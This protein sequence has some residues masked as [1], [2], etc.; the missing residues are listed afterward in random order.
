MQ[1]AI[2][3]GEAMAVASGG[4]RLAATYFPPAPGALP[5]LGV[6]VIVLERQGLWGLNLAV[7]RALAA[8]GYP[9][10]AVDGRGDANG[11]REAARLADVRAAIAAL[12]QRTAAGRVLLFAPIE[13]AGAVARAAAAEGAAGV[14]LAG[15]RL[16]PAAGPADLDV[17]D[18]LAP[19][20]GPLLLLGTGDTEEHGPAVDALVA[21]AAHWRQA[22]ARCHLEMGIVDGPRMMLPQGGDH[23]ISPAN[24]VG[25]A[26]ELTL[27]WIERRYGPG[28]PR[29][30]QGPPPSDQP[31]P[32]PLD[33]SPAAAVPVLTTGSVLLPPDAGLF[34]DG[35]AWSLTLPDGRAFALTDAL[36]RLVAL[37]DGHRNVGQIAAALSAEIG[38]NLP[39]EQVGRLLRE[40]LA[41]LGVLEPDVRGHGGE[42]DSWMTDILIRCYEP[43]DRLRALLDNLT[44]VTRPP[45][46]LILVVGKRHAVLNQHVGLDRART[47]YAVFLDDDVILTEGWVERLRETM[48][49]T[50][51]GAVSARQLRMDGSPLSTAGACGER[52]VVEA[53]SGGACFM[54][55]NDLG[56]RFDETYVRSQWDDVDFMFQLYERGLR[57]YVDGRV[58]FYHHNDP[59]VWR[60]QNL[61]HFVE[62]WLGK[63]LLRGWALY[64]YENASA[65]MPCFGREDWAAGGT[66]ASDVAGARGGGPRRNPTGS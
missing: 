40:R 24:Y 63:G 48:D 7:A 65:F 52:D 26:L 25:V 54:F 38:R 61:R 10:L 30:W 49:R 43:H 41:P 45:Y 4:E 27:Q 23:A 62:K 50:G 16:P 3:S 53:L 66:G 58:D 44:R 36:R 39:A 21:H 32:P 6:A 59:K 13:H 64:T 14:V 2:V 56:L 15:T 22:S 19:Y 42:D 55:R 37:V 18:A 28:Y 35:G 12:R 47:R 8:A 57:A 29:A 1:V 51:A 33:D 11:D 20:E 17:F 60:G 9:T 34:E 31:G 5:S 46:N